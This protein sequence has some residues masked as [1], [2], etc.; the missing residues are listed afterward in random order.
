MFWKA[1]TYIQGICYLMEF[2]L[3]WVQHDASWELAW[4][5]V[6]W[7][8]GGSQKRSQVYIKKRLRFGKPWHIHMQHVT[9]W[10]LCWL[11]CKMWRFG[12]CLDI[13]RCYMLRYGICADIGIYC[14]LHPGVCVELHTCDMLHYGMCV[15]IWICVDIARCLCWHSKMLHC[16]TLG[17]G[18]CV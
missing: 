6:E 9:S 2:V 10:D 18:I 11:R 15:D 13:E 3:T 16:S 14:M 5:R 4:D 8:G 17:Y 1:L 7:R 12:I